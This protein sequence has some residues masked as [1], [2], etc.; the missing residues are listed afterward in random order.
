MVNVA[1][2]AIDSVEKN[3]NVNKLNIDK[4]KEA[5]QHISQVIGNVKKD[6]KKDEQ[7][8]KDL[9]KIDKML[10]NADMKVHIEAI[11]TNLS[12]LVKKADIDSQLDDE[13]KI[14]RAQQVIQHAKKAL[15][16]KTDGKDCNVF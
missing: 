8:K 4:P 2:K 9:R 13:E 16:E 12:E 15:S 11:F 1:K 10:E 7:A 5:V 3:T 14:E 6:L